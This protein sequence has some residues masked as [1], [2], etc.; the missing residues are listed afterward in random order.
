MLCVADLTRLDLIVIF[1]SNLVAAVGVR[2]RWGGQL[3]LSAGNRGS[4]KCRIREVMDIDLG[5]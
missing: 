1:E 3:L 4:D 5:S 2:Q